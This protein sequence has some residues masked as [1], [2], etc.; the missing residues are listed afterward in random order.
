MADKE[1]SIQTVVVSMQA[2][3]ATMLV[4]EVVKVDEVLRALVVEKVLVA[5]MVLKGTASAGILCRA[6]PVALPA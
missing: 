6:R 2:M 1:G 5:V 3:V 4:C